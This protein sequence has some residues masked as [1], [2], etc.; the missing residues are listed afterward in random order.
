[1]IFDRVATRAA[2]FFQSDETFAT[3]LLVL[4]LDE[5][6]TD[7]LNWEGTTLSMEIRDT[8]GVEM[9]QTVADK[10]QAAIGLMVTDQFERDALSFGHVCES[11][12]GKPVDFLFVPQ[13]EPDEIAWAITEWSL[14]SG[15]QVDQLGPDVKRFV[16]AVLADAGIYLPPPLLQFADYP[17]ENGDREETLRDE[18]DAYQSFVSANRSAHEAIESSVRQSLDLLIAE[19]DRLPLR[20]RDTESWK[21]FMDRYRKAGQ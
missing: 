11:L 17:P 13:P 6:G 8:Y 9:S 3:S 21:S 18:P 5:F 7:V 4:V 14:L 15:S 19:L 20:N 12:A 2:V 10:L 1:M 16:G